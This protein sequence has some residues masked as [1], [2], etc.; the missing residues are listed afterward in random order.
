MPKAG[1]L[2]LLWDVESPSPSP[3]ETS[4]GRVEPRRIIKSLR[5][6]SL[7]E[8]SKGQYWLHPVIRAEAVARIRGEA[9][10]QQT[11]AR[12][13][14]F[15]TE[16]VKTIQTAQ[17][18]ITAL[19]AFHHYCEIDDFEQA[20]QVILKSRINQWGQFLP[21]GHT[22]YR[23][24]LLQPVLGATT[25]IID[26]VQSRQ[27]L[28]ELCN[29][30]GDLYWI[31]G[32]VREAIACQEKSIATAIQGL[33]SL[34]ATAENQ[35]A[36]YYLKMLQIDSLLSVGL[37]SIDLWEL[38]QAASLFEQVISLAA[39]TAH[40]SW[41]QKASVCLALVRSYQGFQTEALQAADRAC[42]FLLAPPNT[43]RFAYFIQVLGQTYANLGKHEQALAVYEQAI[44]FSQ[45]GHYTQVKA[46]TLTGLAEIYREHGK[47]ELAISYH[48]KAVELLEKIG[49]K[50]DL[51]QAYFQFGLTSQSA[52]EADKRKIYF[53]Q[54]LQ[55]FTDMQATKQIERMSIESKV[56]NLP[57]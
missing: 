14:E 31:A 2:A 7:V 3:A 45:A 33:S 35:H 24:G 8:F 49:A 27:S 6:R 25:K 39:D 19:E 30:L 46:K 18:A 12:I 57:V 11:H 28:S 36:I 29:I 48:L 40:L 23:L 50:C 26:E 15:W 13:A 21:L 44:A 56:K 20:S 51:A 16:R 37:Y 38:Q 1:L 22:L 10:W 5:D 32:R 9:Q 17:D 42:E 47:F 43:G 54:A 4:L 53:E 55:L 52:G 41:A 34:S